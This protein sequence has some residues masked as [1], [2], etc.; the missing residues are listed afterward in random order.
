MSEELKGPLYLPSPHC[1]RP[2]AAKVTKS[3]TFRMP[4]FGVGAGLRERSPLPRAG[5]SCAPRWTAR[6]PLPRRILSHQSGAGASLLPPQGP[7]QSLAAPETSS[8]VLLKPPS[9]PSP[10]GPA[11]SPRPAAP[12]A[13]VWKAGQTQR[14][15]PDEDSDGVRLGRQRREQKQR[16]RAET[17]QRRSGGPSALPTP[18]A[19]QPAAPG[20]G[21]ARGLGV[22]GARAAPRG[23][24]L[25][26]RSWAR[27]GMDRASAPGLGG[28]LGC[29]NSSRAACARARR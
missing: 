17:E 3:E 9:L 19:P 10:R 16:H 12:Q 24:H 15:G 25:I 23:T 8:V 29:R 4:G 5:S 14:R 20:P 26:R 7:G 18:P 1:S 21:P 28:A 27:S 11:R 2:F 22:G 13:P 6:A